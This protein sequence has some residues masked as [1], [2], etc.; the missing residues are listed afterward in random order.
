MLGKAFM[1]AGMVL[2]L[3]GFLANFNPIVVV[4]LSTTLCLYVVVHTYDK[5]VKM[6]IAVFPKI[7]CSLKPPSFK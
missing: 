7:F 5:V 1:A 6:Q 4:T 3:K 2:F